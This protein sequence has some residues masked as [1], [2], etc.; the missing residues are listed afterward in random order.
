VK[1]FSPLTAILASLPSPNSGG[2]LCIRGF[3]PDLFLPLIRSVDCKLFITVPDNRFSS[4]S[5]Y[6]SIL[7]DDESVVFVT[8]PYSDNNVPPGFAYSENHLIVRAKELLAGG[9]ESIQTIFCSVGGVTM[10]VLG[11]GIENKLVFSAA[12]S[13]KGC[14]EFLVLEN[15]VLAEFVTM[16]GEYSVRG[17]II[18]V[19]PFCG[20]DEWYLW[21]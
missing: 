11:C 9:L 1:Q 12:V 4:I 10:P 20:P 15:Y 16:P 21:L 13:Y 14:R 18:D 19:F 5:K 6:L 7:W 8:Q 17:G 2:G 3:H